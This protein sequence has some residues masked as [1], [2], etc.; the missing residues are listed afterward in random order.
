MIGR[1]S[2]ENMIYLIDFGLSRSL[3]LSRPV[4]LSKPNKDNKAIGTAVYA[5]LNAHY[6]SRYLPRDDLE[7]MMYLISYFAIGTLPWKEC[8]TTPEG[9][10]EIVRLKTETKPVDLFKGFPDQLPEML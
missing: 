1:R 5:S 2:K 6:K 8:G 7:S 9:L 3:D 4:T 10:K